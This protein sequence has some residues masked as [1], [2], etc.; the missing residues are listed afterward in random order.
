M[1]LLKQR[2]LN[3]GEALNENVLKVDSFL[4]HQIDPLLMKEIGQEFIHRFEDVEF[5][6][7]LTLESSGIAPSVMVGMILDIPVVFGRKRQSLTLNDNLYT[8]QVFSYTKQETN[9]IAVAKKF[10]S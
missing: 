9:T 10:L 7:V 5:T 1:D 2:I 3:D 6:K 8:S 4:N